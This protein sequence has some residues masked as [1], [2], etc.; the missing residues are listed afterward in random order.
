MIAHAEY[1]TYTVLLLKY[2]IKYSFKRIF[3]RSRSV[4][5]FPN[6]NKIKRATP[7]NLASYSFQRKIVNEISYP[8]TKITIATGCKIFKTGKWPRYGAI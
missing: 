6:G 3:A 4:I 5:A 7:F 8:S 1:P 2:K